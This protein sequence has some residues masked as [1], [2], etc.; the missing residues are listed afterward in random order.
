MAQ[1][2]ITIQADT[3]LKIRYCIDPDWHPYESL[4]QNIHTGISSD[5]IAMLTQRTGIETELIP[6]NSWLETIELLKSG[7]CDL[8]P[9]LNKTTEREE[10]LYFSEVWYRAPNVLLSLKDEPFLQGLENIE[11]RTV[12][13]TEGYRI[14]EYVLKHYPDIN[15][16]LVANEVEGINAVINNEVDVFIGSMLST[17]NYIQSNGY[18]EIKIA[19][20]A[21]PEDL[22]RVGVT[23]QNQALIPIIDQFIAQIS[24]AEQINMFRKWNN[25]SYIDNT[26][27]KL[28]KNI[29]L[30]FSVLLM[31]G[32][33]YHQL[34][35]KFNKQLIVQ[36]KQLESLKTK[37][38]KTNQELLFLTHHDLL[39]EI[40]NRHYFNQAISNE[41]NDLSQNGPIS[42][43]FFDIDHFKSINDI[44]GHSVGDMALKKLATTIKG[45][46]DE[47][48][49]FVRWG[50]E[51]FIVL[52]RK[53]NKR[54]ANLLCQNL[55]N[56]IK[57]IVLEPDVK[58]TCSYGIAEKLSK[59][60]IMQCIERADQAMYQAKTNGRDCIIVAT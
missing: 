50:G 47:R 60:T 19:G 9:I 49:T 59:E 36:N 41:E 21:G 12:A 14:T 2:P 44:H 3:P 6:T 26:N 58:I 55:N 34:V 13:M 16:S 20:W 4:K 56:H 40:Y 46:L 54:E 51:E 32:F 27:Y 25:V 8:T 53:T 7:Q 5:F 52:C 57:N 29:T 11:N 45:L 37:L 18:D 15:A 30:F 22:L 1:D 42:V 35:R 31:T 28:T 43:V 48:H 10:F 24:E 33:I 38:I 39:T 23:K 17:N